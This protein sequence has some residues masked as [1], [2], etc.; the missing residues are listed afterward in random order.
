MVHNFMMPPKGKSSITLQRAGEEGVSL[1][2]WGEGSLILSHIRR[3]GP[4]LGVQILNFNIFGGR[5][6]QKDVY[7]FFLFFLWGG[8]GVGDMMTLWAF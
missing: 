6:V 2:C 8:G 3:L 5:G 4:F 1:W 7:L